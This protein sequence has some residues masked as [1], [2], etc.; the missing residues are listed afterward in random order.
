VKSYNSSGVRTRTF[1]S[2]AISN[3]RA[4]TFAVMPPP[5]PPSRL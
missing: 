2:H 1:S 3:P 5:T 4:T